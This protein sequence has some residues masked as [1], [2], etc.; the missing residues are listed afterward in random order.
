MIDNCRGKVSIIIPVYNSKEYLEELFSSLESQTYKNIEIILVDD[1]STDGS[2]EACENFKRRDKRVKLYR[3]N[4]MGSSAARNV[5]LEKMT[6]QYVTFIDSDDTIDPDY[7]SSFMEKI[8]K[9]NENIIVQEGLDTSKYGDAPYSSFRRKEN[10]LEWY[11]LM[12][13]EKISTGTMAKMVPA[14]TIKRIR[15]DKKYAVGEDAYFYYSIVNSLDDVEV[16][17]DTSIKKYH[18]YRRENSL[19]DK[20]NNIE[21]WNSNLEVF[22]AMRDEASNAKIRL[23]A[24]KGLYLLMVSILI[25]NLKSKTYNRQYGLE[26]HQELRSLDVFIP[27]NQNLKRIVRIITVRLFYN[28]LR[29]VFFVKRS[30]FG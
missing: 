16:I 14:A 12:M 7:I 19:T 9:G 18:Y 1:G 2:G 3:Q 21:S 6:G 30:I 29:L 25:R 20:N 13:T 28:P 27:N 26:L 17:I 5:G 10:M 15:F 11:D 23:S 22:R 4:N 24:T 8:D